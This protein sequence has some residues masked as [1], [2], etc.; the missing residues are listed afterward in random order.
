MERFKRNIFLFGAGAIIDWGG[1]IT[2]ELTD[3]IVEYGFKA[4]D[5]KTITFHIKQILE[6][7]GHSVNFET[8]LSV[9]EELIILAL[10]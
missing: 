3:S 4:K 6:Q 8:I 1:P 9:I 7:D 10:F 2:S 5:G